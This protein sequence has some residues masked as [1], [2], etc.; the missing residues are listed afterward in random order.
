MHWRSFYNR[1]SRLLIGLLLVFLTV[2]CS[3]TKIV[4]QPVPVLPAAPEALLLP[5]SFP[6]LKGNT[7]LSLWQYKE[8]LEESLCKCNNDKELMRE[9]YEQTKKMINK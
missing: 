2:S 4:P 9:W 5:T 3:S 8:A 1:I 6:E 7:N